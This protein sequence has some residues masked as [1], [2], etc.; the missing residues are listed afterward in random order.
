MGPAGLWTSAGQPF[1]AKRL[2]A[3]NSADLISIYIHI[4]NLHAL[5]HKFCRLIDSGVDAEGEAITR[6][7]DL[8]ANRIQ[9]VSFETQYVQDWPKHVPFWHM[10]GID[11]EDMRRKENPVC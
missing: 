4:S 9:V 8:I 7:V 10:T 2:R 11:R 6:C 3:N 5:A 1:A